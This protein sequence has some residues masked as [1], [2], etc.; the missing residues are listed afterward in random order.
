MLF[1]Y[2]NVKVQKILTDY[3]ILQKKVGA[4]IAKKI[5]MRMHQL[6]AADNFNLYLTKIPLGNP[7]PLKGDFENCYGISITANY[8]LVVEPLYTRKDL[9]SLKECNYI[10]IKGVL[11]YHGEKNE[12]I[13]P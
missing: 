12:W 6:E 8:R 11:D 2:D 10:K 1:E 3:D 9:E 7:H 13:I 4:E 5:I